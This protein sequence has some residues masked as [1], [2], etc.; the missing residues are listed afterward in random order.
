M[1]K[2]YRSIWNE[3]T[4]TFVAVSEIASAATKKK[5]KARKLLE[6]DEK[7]VVAHPM[8]LE[9]RFMFDAAAVL[10]LNGIGSLGTDHIL[11]L[12]DAAAGLAA[13][14]AIAAD[15]ENDLGNWNGG[16]LTVQR[17]TSGGVADGSINDVFNF[18]S[19]SNFSVTG[20]S[21]TRGSDSSGTLVASIGST[22]FATWT[23]TS[24]TGKL[25]I[26]FDGDAS[27][28][29]VQDVV[30][31]IGYSNAT[32]YGTATIRM[33]LND[34]AGT[35]NAD[36]TVT[37]SV[38]YVDE[39]S[40]DA[41]GDAADGFN[42]AE[43]LAKAVDGD[44][45]LIE[46]GTYRGQ[47]VATKAVSIDAALGA[48][49][50][51]TLEAPDRADLQFSTQ[52]TINGRLRMPILDLRTTTPGSGTISVSNLTIDGR[53][54]APLSSG[55]GNGS[56]DM[57][58]IATY[59]TN[60]VIDNVTI[61]HISTEVDGV[62]GD[63]SG[64]SENFGILAEGSSNLS[65]AVTLTV[66]NSTINTF[67]KTGILAWGPKLDVDIRDNT[68]TAVGVHGLSNQNG[69]QIGSG[70]TRAGTTGVIS[71]NTIENIG[72]TSDS[73][74]ATGILLR[75]VGAGVVVS[76]NVITSDG[77]PGANPTL[78]STGVSLYEA[79]NAVTLTGNTFNQVTAGILVEAPYGPLGTY[80]A[81][82]V[83]QNNNFSSTD[84]AIYD[85]QDGV[86]P[87]YDQQAQNALTITLNS[88]A[89]VTNSKGYLEYVL[90]G[91]DDSFTDTG[92]APSHIDG[93]AGD[94][95]LVAG[96]GDDLL[97]GG[98]GA[99]TL[100]GGD[101]DDQFD[102]AP[103]DNLS[104]DKITDFSV[105]DHIHLVDRTLSGV[106]AGDGVNVAANGV[107]VGTYDSVND[108]TTLYVD[109]DG[110]D[111]TSAMAIK[112]VGNYTGRIR[113]DSGDIYVNQ[114]PELSTPTTASY[115]DTAAA[116]TFNNNTGTL[117]AT[118]SEGSTLS[119][120]ISGGTTGGNTTI[121]STTYDVSKAGTY[122]TLY[123]NS[124]TGAYVFVPDADAINGLSGNTSETFT[125]TS[126]DG[127]ITDNDTYTVNLT[128]VND[129]P[130]MTTPTAASYTDTAAVDTFNNNSG[131]LAATDS[132]GSTLSYGISGG[133]TGGNTIIGSTTYDVSKAGT[134]GTLYV[135]STTGAYVFVPD[136]DA[137]NGLSGNASESFTVTSSDGV[138]TGSTTYMVNLSGANDPL[139]QSTPTAASYTDTSAADT[140]NNNSGT[141]AA[142]DPEG[143]T[144]SYGI[145]SGTTGGNT[146]IGFTTY[147][148]S[149][150]GTYGTLYVNSTTG[151]YV[152]VP[153]A[154]AINGL[155]ANTSETFTVTSTDGATT[156][157][158]TYT[159]NLTGVNDT[160]LLNTPTAASYN[161]TAI[162]DT[163]TANT[164]T[165]VG[166]DRD[167][168]TTLTYGITGGTVVSGVSTKVGSYGSLSVNT[169]TGAYTYTPDASAINALTV[170]ATDT[171]TVTVND[172]S[173]GTNT[174]TYT[175]NLNSVNDIPSLT[176]PAT[177]RYIDTAAND[178]FTADAGTL[179]GIDRDSAQTLSYGISGGRTAS[180]VSTKVG[181]FGSL[182]V[183][184]STGAYIYS[185]N[186]A[187][188][189]ALTANATDT[190]TVTVS[191]GNGGSATATYTVNLTAANDTPSLAAPSAVSY[192]NTAI[193]DT[194]TTNTGTLL[195]TDRDSGTTLT[196]GVAGGT[197]VS[198][199]SSK[200]GSYGRLSVNTS[201]G[202][203]TY[204]PDAT[205]INAITANTVDIF[206]VTVSDGNGGTSS[207]TYTVN[208][209]VSNN[210][211][212]LATPATA[213]YTDTAA[214]DTFTADTGVLKG[215]DQDIGQ[216][217]TY[218]VAGGTVISG[219]STKAGNYGS[220][221]VNIAT[222][223]YI[224]SPNNTAIN[225]LT[226]NATD[227]FTVSVSDGHGGSTTSTYT[228]NLTGAN[229]TPVVTSQ[230]KVMLPENAS[231][232][233][234]VYTVTATDADAG[235][236]LIFSL[237]GT[238][239]NF[240]DI[241]PA[242]GEVKLKA[243]VNYEVKSSYTFNVVVTDSGAGMLSSSQAVTLTVTD[244][245][246]PTTGSLTIN[247]IAKQGET[248]TVTDTLADEDR[249]IGKT[250]QWYADGQL[251]SDA[252]QSTLVLGPSLVGKVIT[253]KAI[254]TDS[255]GRKEVVTSAGTGAVVNVNDPTSGEVIVSGD[256]GLGQTLTVS[257]TLSDLDGMGPVTYQWQY[258]DAN[259]QWQNITLTNG[260][261]ATG[262][263]YTVESQHAFQELRVKASFTDGQGTA[264]VVY[265]NSN[266]KFVG[267]SPISPTTVSV[268]VTAPPVMQAAPMNMVHAPVVMFISPG[269][270]TAVSMLTANVVSESFVSE[271][272]TGPVVILG[273]EGAPSTGISGLRAVEAS[274]DIVIEPGE[275]TSFTLPAGT[276]IHSDAAARVSL[277]ARLVDGRPLPDYVKFNPTTGTFTVDAE[278]DQKVEQLQVIV[279][280]VDDQGQSAS[281]TVVI[282]LKDKARHSSKSELP[283]K[284]GKLALA[285]QIRLTD[286]PAGHLAELAALSKAFLVSTTERSRASA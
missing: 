276:F 131:T 217:L 29:L 286:Q 284:L 233:A 271:Q 3:V 104:G 242:T 66:T 159:V 261:L 175:V 69:M 235:Q 63:Y 93:G 231:T 51:V 133:T 8:A 277:S 88:L 268:S 77:T 71:G 193:I 259:G 236:G 182:S 36:V 283:I 267:L 254:Y 125:V 43:A 58:G 21:V 226:A 239:A 9:Q 183:N 76:D 160:P 56:Q 186:N 54:Q 24:L 260:Q 154:V 278:I 136:T 90:F 282:K 128:G 264:V 14:T 130:V 110:D 92:A 53:D 237:S 229:D 200:V 158:A 192:T 124:T 153:N 165:L 99:D 209:V 232:S 27:S 23:Y 114:V 247:G 123:V 62:T 22:Q 191:D 42:L 70:G 49:G 241:N 26:S 91:G 243:S 202:A 270:D 89:T 230:A 255:V 28:A 115:T 85:S 112:L 151:A 15:A 113:T 157:N 227:T 167:S 50:A 162:I 149:K 212:T 220:L 180:G 139:V 72:T 86:D 225:A 248:L 82:H 59:D 285:E 6:V 147:D 184:I 256:S 199:V 109:T 126:S 201:T 280:A 102:F 107:E 48:A 117:A 12:A 281:T 64:Y 16:N 118:D 213:R 111:S 211:P 31:H 142:T 203:Y 141:L 224:Y 169:S 68:I 100:T 11:A 244:A 204:T 221:S 81:A 257:N 155:S 196:Y 47:F 274:R 215:A 83:I 156:D 245:N 73:Y 194:F 138:T 197:V 87:A 135:N 18:L 57:I 116:D 19:S 240:F 279:N 206:S 103:T 251:I 178:T 84:I 161:N 223:A 177:A 222:G 74:S 150:A 39:T 38:I 95:T 210:P 249:I 145:S 214:N 250:Y 207:A 234:V 188:I 198:G 171:F 108:T 174:A 143:A 275:Q 25:E 132:E 122:G 170:N 187:A 2:F 40:Y 246:D 258:K 97:I 35:T 173:G 79:G 119:Y 179:I 5:N 52:N 265:S 20:G 1:N 10:D 263:H 7:R 121:G 208:L 205:A 94:D 176:T 216:T 98:T 252:N 137:I 61:K 32:P 44:S 228:V 272:A 269:M 30:R 238:D 96:S 134:Y 78:G 168:G 129:A 195:G 55:H 253:V 181:D 37:S 218:E 80:D 65:S 4:Q 172:G 152:F 266:L 34:G 163:F 189:N 185:P 17:V 219:V 45:I 33:G 101:G 148:V 67:Q 106:M 273:L 190:F 164:G 41:Q 140:F 120:G 13:A 46:D 166:A 60:A 75:Q 146:T 127:S 262:D 144:L 105:G